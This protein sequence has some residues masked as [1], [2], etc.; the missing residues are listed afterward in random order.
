MEPR[1]SIVLI[2]GVG[3]IAALVILCAARDREPEPREAIQEPTAGPL[4]A[5]T[6]GRH[7]ETPE[8]AS[9]VTQPPSPRSSGPPAEADPQFET[10]QALMVELRRH[11]PVEAEIRLK[12]A[13]LGNERYPDGQHAAERLHTVVQA[14]S[15]L[16][17]HDE[18]QEAADEILARFPGTPWAEDVYRHMKI[19]PRR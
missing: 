13:R 19:H 11:L 17:R 14:L 10:E 4:S 6:L 2:A 15:A 1:R 18:A 5:P 3:V 12:L 9:R 8:L 16:G 7:R